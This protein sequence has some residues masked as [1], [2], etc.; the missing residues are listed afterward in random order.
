MAEINRQQDV[1]CQLY[2]GNRQIFRETCHQDVRSDSAQSRQK[3]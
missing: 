2:N 1:V 3:R